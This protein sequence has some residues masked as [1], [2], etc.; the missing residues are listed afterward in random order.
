MEVAS[1]Q[2]E[3]DEIN[4]LLSV[5]YE[6]ADSIIVKNKD[7]SLLKKTLNDLKNVHFSMQR[8]SVKAIGIADTGERAFLLT[9]MGSQISRNWVFDE[10]VNKWLGERDV[11]QEKIESLLRIP[12]SLRSHTSRSRSHWL[13]RNSTSSTQRTQAVAKEEVARLKLAYLKQKQ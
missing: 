3:H 9:S 10:N 7:V 12:K 4:A 6:E 11:S 1:L 8:L 5:L 13:G 2:K